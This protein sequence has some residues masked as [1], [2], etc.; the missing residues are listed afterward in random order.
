MLY[1]LNTI[2]LNKNGS[3]LLL[4][5]KVIN[6]V[7]VFFNLCEPLAFGHFGFHGSSHV[8]LR[9][10]VYVNAVI[11]GV[12]AYDLNSQN[13]ICSGLLGFSLIRH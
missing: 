4:L 9:K 6:L 12:L 7:D 11:L 1:N 13:Y 8:N 5:Y 2:C 3:E 10:Y